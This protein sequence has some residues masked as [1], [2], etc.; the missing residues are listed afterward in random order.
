MDDEHNNDN[1]ER[2]QEGRGAEG[3]N[4]SGENFRWP[5]HGFYI[6]NYSVT[7]PMDGQPQQQQPSDSNNNSNESNENTRTNGN[8]NNFGGFPIFGPGVFFLN[9]NGQPTPNDSNGSGAQPMEGVEFGFEFGG[10]ANNN[11]NGG[12]HPLAGLFGNPTKPRASER[13]I[14]KL[15]QVSEDELGP[16]GANC[17]I[18]YEKYDLIKKEDISNDESDDP[19]VSIPQN[20]DDIQETQITIETENTND[21]DDPIESVP[22]DNTNAHDEDPDTSV[23][24]TNNNSHGEDDDDPPES[25]PESGRQSD[26]RPVE[27]PCG[28]RFG[29]SCIKEWL[30]SSNTCPL[31]RTPLES[32]D[33]YLRSTGQEP[34]HGRGANGILNFL[35]QQVPEVFN[36]IRREVNGNENN[37]NDNNENNATH[38]TTNF[39]NNIPLHLHIVRDDDGFYRTHTNRQNADEP[40]QQDQPSSSEE[41]QQPPQ[42]DQHQARH[43]FLNGATF[44]ELMRAFTTPSSQQSNATNSNSMSPFRLARQIFD[45]TTNN[46]SNRNRDSR[47]HPY[48]RSSASNT[49][50]DSDQSRSLQCASLPLSLCV[51]DSEN[52][53]IINLDCGHGYHDGCLQMAMRAHGDEMDSMVDTDGVWCTRC[54]RYQTV[55]R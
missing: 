2:Q 31:C 41:S 51:G 25:V 53:P 34:E 46:N 17:A 54:R 29:E 33:E 44:S 16:H 24:G 40:Q 30:G 50:D 38:H 27:L 12:Q 47:H 10:G 39:N 14:S 35:F 36:I 37:N 32:Q 5:P 13:A 48:N 18:C 28:H 22:E 52:E 1:N 4:N 6:L 20:I 42:H 21:D 55:I 45:S 11:N 26:H 19:P 9:G 43:T 8:N 23:P 49:D 7:L 3:T 15:K